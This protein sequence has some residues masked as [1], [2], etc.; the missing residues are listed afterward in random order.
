MLKD[1]QI[2]L[3][4]ATD[5]FICLVRWRYRFVVPPAAVLLNMAKRH[6]EHPPGRPL[7]D[8]ARYFHDC[9]RDPG[10][11][12]GLERTTPPSAMALRFFMTVVRTI[13]EFVVD[14]LH[15]GAFTD[16]QHER[17]AAWV[18]REFLPHPPVSMGTKGLGHLAE[19]TAEVFLQSA[20]FRM[21][22]RDTPGRS[23]RFLT[24]VCRKLG[25]SE[26]EF[27]DISTRTILM[28]LSKS[29]E[30]PDR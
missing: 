25:V 17:L 27:A 9:M 13:A 8:V 14:A 28:S 16:D 10:L 22:E 30:E 12:S 20:L 19:R 18:V 11:F 24:H 21:V 6:R 7:R 4:R 2:S 29:A 1:N 15:S 26:S 3:D 23:H 5:C